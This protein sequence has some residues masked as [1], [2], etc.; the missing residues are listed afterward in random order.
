MSTLTATS[1]TAEVAAWCCSN[2]LRASVVGS[3]VWVP[4][5]QLGYH[6]RD[7][8]LKALVMGAGG[9]RPSK[10]RQT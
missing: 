10:R 3:W 6:R 2:G 9:F 1:T 7:A 5:R 4:Y 8:E